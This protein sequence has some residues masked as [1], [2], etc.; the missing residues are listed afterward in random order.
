METNKEK[1]ALPEGSEEVQFDYIANMMDEIEE[2][3]F[4]ELVF[5]IDTNYKNEWMVEIYEHADEDETDDCSFD[6]LEMVDWYTG[7]SL[8]DVFDFLME[9]YV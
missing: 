8:K 4:N 5:K 1:Y 2:S 7:K 9:R 6:D 3:T